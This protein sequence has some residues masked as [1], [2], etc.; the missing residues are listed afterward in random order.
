[1]C[2]RICVKVFASASACLAMHGWVI[3]RVLLRACNTKKHQRGAL[4]VSPA[5]FRTTAP[6]LGDRICFWD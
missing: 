3:Q 1:M 6:A 2:V 4:F 5:E